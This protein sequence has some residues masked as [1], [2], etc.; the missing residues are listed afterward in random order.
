MGSPSVKIHN[1]K[2]DNYHALQT[3]GKEQSKEHNSKKQKV[4]V[5]LEK[6]VGRPPT[7]KQKIK[8]TGNTW[9]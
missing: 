8:E 7:A 4:G 2:K 1:I 3:T 9:N 6:E 5:K